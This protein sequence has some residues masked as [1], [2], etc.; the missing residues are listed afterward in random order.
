M[1]RKAVNILSALKDEALNEL[2]G[3]ILPFWMNR[4]VDD[5]RGGFLGR[6]D[7][8]NRIIYDAPK[9][10]I[11]NARILWTFSASYLELRNPLYL[12]M[13]TMANDYIMTHFFDEIHGGTFWS[14]TPGGDPLD[15]KKQIYSQAFFLY[16]L[17]QYF[18]ATGDEVSKS[19]AIELF[20][21]IEKHSFDKEANG[22]FEAFD[23]SWG[24][25]DDLRL[26]EKDANEKKSMNTHLHILEAYTT[27]YRIWPD[28][29]LGLQLRNLIIVFLEKILDKMTSHLN[30]FFDEL[31]QCKSTRISYGHDIEASWLLHEAA[32]VLSDSDIL[33]K[34]TVA[35][36]NI[37]KAAIEGLQE[38]GSLIYER[39]DAAGLVDRD[40]HWWVQAEAVIGFLNA[41]K[42]TGDKSYLYLSAGCFDYIKTK[43]IDARNGEWYWSR[44]SDGTVNTKDDKAGFWKCPYHNSRMCLEIMNRLTY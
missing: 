17:S 29:Y 9:G 11:L 7:G 1:T 22:Y 37:A 5:R 36:V 20:R 21:L 32:K 4:A 33:E 13:A 42:I 8:N 12:K 28:E 34:V 39:D 23:R 40:R 6:I 30:L 16:A 24:D 2:T 38:D 26:S 18:M 25:L 19:N 41:F 10:A 43:L 15:T 31:W 35:S 27:L 44:R 14:L 3:N